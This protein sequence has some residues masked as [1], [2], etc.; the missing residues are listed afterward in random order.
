MPAQVVVVLADRETRQAVVRALREA[1]LDAVAFENALSAL[2]AFEKDSRAR[3]VVANANGP[4]GT[5]GGVSLLRMLR[6]KQ[7]KA[8]GTSNLRA[9]LIGQ[10]EEREHV[11][12][13]GR[14]F[15][16]QP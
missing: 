9:V 4:A 13:V 15:A 7:I 11:A 2:A 14:D 16:C 12:G 6:Y 1:M 5:L 8:S 3:I 10:P